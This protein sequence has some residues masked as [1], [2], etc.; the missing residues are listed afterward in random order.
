MGWGWSRQLEEKDLRAR[1]ILLVYELKTLLSQSAGPDISPRVVEIGQPGF[2][3]YR[4]YL[5]KTSLTVLF[6]NESGIFKFISFDFR[7]CQH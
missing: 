3:V 6:R 2:W 5:N 7:N 4:I 1:D